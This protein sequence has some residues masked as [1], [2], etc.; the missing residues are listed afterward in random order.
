[1]SLSGSYRNNQG[2]FH[3]FR[4]DTRDPSKMAEESR[5]EC[6]YDSILG[7]EVLVISRTMNNPQ[8]NLNHTVDSLSS[9]HPS[10]ISCA[11]MLM[12]KAESS[13]AF[14]S[15]EFTGPHYDAD[16]I[17]LYGGRATANSIRTT[18]S[19]YTVNSSNDDEDD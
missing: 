5:L 1:M 13:I 10:D 18:N 17:E 14:E 15:N 11:N 3:G 8:I 7:S 19:D 12:S 6:F 4:I 9:R 2:A 16:T